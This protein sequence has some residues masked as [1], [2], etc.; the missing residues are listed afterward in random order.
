LLFGAKPFM[1]N[2]VS[3]VIDFAMLGASIAF[4]LFARR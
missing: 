4:V 3:L 2:T 1:S